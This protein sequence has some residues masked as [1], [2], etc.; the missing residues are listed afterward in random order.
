[1]SKPPE[2]KLLTRICRQN[3]GTSLK[4]QEMLANWNSKKFDHFRNQNE[5]QSILFYQKQ[6]RKNM[7]I[8]V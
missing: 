6:K 2:K 4:I 5:F 7:P 1:M 3:I 8:C